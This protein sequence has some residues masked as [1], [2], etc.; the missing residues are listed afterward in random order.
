MRVAVLQARMSSTRLPGKVLA[1]V[2]GEPMVLRQIERLRQCNG[3]DLLVLATS[4]DPSDDE[5]V[6]AAEGA[7]VTVRRG[8]LADVLGRFAGVVDEFDPETLIRL[9]ADCPLCDPD[10][11]DRVIAEHTAAR[12]DYTSNVI[13]RTYPQGL[14]V[15]CVSAEAFRRL[16]ELELT[17]EEHEHVTLGIYRRAEE[18]TL[19]SVEQQTDLSKLRWTVDRPDDLAFVQ[20][21]FDSL[22]PLSPRFRQADVLELIERRPDLRHVN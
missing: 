6:A 3:I 2:A 15:E 17:D 22:Y 10:V 20:E 7:G 11:I 12:A 21:V 1:P 8:S 16:R 19:H 13:R 9:T 5:L 4:T 18:F 14:D